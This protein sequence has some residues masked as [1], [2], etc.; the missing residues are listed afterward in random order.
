M[1]VAALAGIASLWAFGASAACTADAEEANLD[2]TLKD[3]LG[4]DVHFCSYAGN[5][6][7][8]DFWATW[9]APCRVEI[10]GF[11]EMVEDY[12]ERGLVILGVSV[13]DTPEALLPYA[14]ELGMNYP[15]LVG[16][17]RDDIKD[18]YGPLIGFPTA[19]IID[20][21]GTICHQHTGYAP[22]SQFVAE[23]EALL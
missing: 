22:K 16:L 3:M 12:G 14:E 8:L 4:V 1:K 11:V 20:R 15:V 5:V 13:D 21:D 18:A 6:I 19:F 10:P 17:D 7:L 23:I 9:C 2:F